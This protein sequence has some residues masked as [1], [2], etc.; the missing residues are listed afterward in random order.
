MMLYWL[1]KETGHERPKYKGTNKKK[2][3]DNTQPLSPNPHP[4][5]NQ[6]PS[7]YPIP[8]MIHNNNT[9]DTEFLVWDNLID[10]E[11]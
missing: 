10:P 6:P 9:M 11:V 3:W 2:L 5:M 8:P 1:T 7:T 4:V